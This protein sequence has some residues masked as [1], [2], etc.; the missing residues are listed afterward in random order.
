MKCICQNVRGYLQDNNNGQTIGSN[1]MQLTY[2]PG[3]GTNRNDACKD[4][5]SVCAF[6]KS[7]LWPTAVFEAALTAKKDDKAYM[8]MAG[9][10][11]SISCNEFPFN[12]S[13]E[14]GS[15]ANAACVTS[16]Q[17][18]YQG[19]INNLV[20][21]VYDL[22]E[23]SSWSPRAP[24]PKWNGGKRLYTINLFDSSTNGNDLSSP[25]AGTWKSSANTPSGGLTQ[26]VGGIN[27]QGNLQYQLGV[28][29]DVQ[30]GI[31]VQ[32]EDDDE[33][34]IKTENDG[35][36]MDIIEEI[37]KEIEVLDIAKKYPAEAVI[38]PSPRLGPGHVHG[39]RHY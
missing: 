12:A 11:D 23:D 35:F 38:T 31:S 2:L 4:V 39:R 1:W 18:F 26:V 19:Q 16:D 25:Y 5:S 14:G 3:G 22:K 27:L 36:E 6:T 30:N 28:N 21:N 13:E 17:Q 9:Y 29:G 8:N 10:S 33:E 37:T 20:S 32:L 24:K 15:G 34:L 7:Y